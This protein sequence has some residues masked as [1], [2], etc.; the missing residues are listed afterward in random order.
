MTRF[1]FVAWGS[2]SLWERAGVR[3]LSGLESK[4]NIFLR[5]TL[6]EKKKATNEQDGKQKRE[7]AKMPFDELLNRRSEQSQ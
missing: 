3:E 2:L 6:G 7:P 5:T 4:R 1:E